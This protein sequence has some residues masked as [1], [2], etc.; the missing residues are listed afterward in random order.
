MERGWTSR[1]LL[2]GV[3]AFWAS[4]SIIARNPIGIPHAE[5]LI[6]VSV[7]LWGVMILAVAILIRLGLDRRATVYACFIAGVFVVTGGALV[8]QRG[9]LLTWLLVLASVLLVHRLTIRM[10]GSA[11]PDVLVVVVACGLLSGPV[12]DGYRSTADFGESAVPEA[13]MSVGQLSS[14]GP[15]VYLVVLDGFPGRHT[16][17]MDFEPGT[18][19]GFQEQVAAM[20][21]QAPADSWTSYPATS[22]SI[23]SL[24]AMSYPLQ[25]EASNLATLLDLYRIVGGDNP[26]R[27]GFADAGYSTW[28]V[29]SGWSGS[30]CR[31]FDNCVESPWL[32]EST[33]HMLR[34]SLFSFTVPVTGHWYAGTFESTSSWLYQ[35]LS[36]L[37]ADPLS[38]FVFAHVL[39]PH[40]P[41]FLESDCSIALEDDRSGYFFTRPGVSID[42]RSRYLEES[43]RCV[44]TLMET[45][46]RT[47]DPGAFL[48]FVSDHGTERRDQL[49]TDPTTWSDEA[50]VERMN[51][52]VL[53]RTPGCDLG[54][55]VYLVNLFRR[56]F[57]C[58]SDENY[59]DLPEERFLFAREWPE[60]HGHLRMPDG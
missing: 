44:Q 32:D 18:Y 31:S 49:F 59:E 54:D 36:E 13:E 25:A 58:L 1:A 40:P 26:I 53:A 52:W 14:T 20:G 23:P 29:E 55:A 42:D 27:R 5:R 16:L 51:A 4:A 22:Y 57:S 28:M 47:V 46:A 3:P 24:L 56:V 11:V 35:R 10:A 8:R 6:I 33:Y 30:N 19:E 34:H 17:E 60:Q 41:Y 9:P 37:S 15:D 21:F 39:A 2:L 45:L 7:G 50:I 48:I 12:I 43:V 38:D